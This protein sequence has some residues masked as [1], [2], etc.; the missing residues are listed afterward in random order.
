MSIVKT[1]ILTSSIVIL[2]ALSICSAAQ[3]MENQNNK[4]QSAYQ[5]VADV[6]AGQAQV[7]YYRSGDMSKAA[8][9]ADIYV[10]GE[11]QTALP[12]AMYTAFCVPAGRHSLGAYIG[13]DPL[14]KG[15]KENLREI[16][17]ETGKTYYAE[18][19]ESALNVLNVV[20]K[21]QATPVLLNTKHQDVLLSRASAVTPCKYLYTDHVLSGDV[22]FDFGKYSERDLKPEGREAIHKLAQTEMP[23]AKITV[24]GHTDP[25]GKESRNLVLGLKRAQT[26][27]NI[28]I[29]NG[30]K[31]E[32]VT[33]SS[34]GSKE[35]LATGCESQSRTLKIQCY[36]PDRRVVI[37]ISRH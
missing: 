14:Y 27:R 8:K 35:P 23:D 18:V 6:A 1:K 33:I 22:L 7:V 19:D 2:A 4:Q 24:I 34:S 5:P 29:E 32:N 3:A 17:L 20:K 26:V 15:K 21:S 9:N 30:I 10:D 11:F 13:D 12:P 37:R 25:I 16:M 36:A 28:L 31:T